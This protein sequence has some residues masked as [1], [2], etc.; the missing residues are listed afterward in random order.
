[1]ALDPDWQS[2]TND[3]SATSIVL[4]L[5]DWGGDAA[6][7]FLL[8][9]SSGGPL[10]DFNQPSWGKVDTF[11]VGT[12]IGADVM[13]ETW[14]SYEPNTADLE[15]T[16]GAASP[17]P[18]CTLIIGRYP[19]SSFSAADYDLENDTPWHVS[20]DGTDVISAVCGLSTSSG[21][22]PTVT[23]GDVEFVH[24]EQYDSIDNP[25][26]GGLSTWVSDLGGAFA[27]NAN[28]NAMLQHVHILYQGEPV[29]VPASGGWSAGWG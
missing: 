5:P 4:N 13:F 24:Q 12:Y 2:V 21:G 22:A 8:Y 28:G 18:A 9:D 6:V 16:I 25:V 14:I 27:L 3:G 15:L 20:V 11:D 1:M 26:V 29:V 19:F 23:N 17:I 7:A 10:S